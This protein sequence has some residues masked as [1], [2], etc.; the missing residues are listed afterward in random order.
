MKIGFILRNLVFLGLFACVFSTLRASSFIPLTQDELVSSADAIIRGHVQSLDSTRDESGNIVTFIGIAVDHDFL[1]QIPAG[2]TLYF[3]E[4]GGSFQGISAWAYGAAELEVGEDVVV[5]A[6]LQPDGFFQIA[7]MFQGKFGVDN[8]GRLQQDTP[9]EV[10][11]F[12]RQTKQFETLDE[13]ESASRTVTPRGLG[14]FHTELNLERSE[15]LVRFSFRGVSEGGPGGGIKKSTLAGTTTVDQNYTL[16]GGGIRWRQFDTNGTV[17]FFVNTA[18]APGGAAN[19]TTSVNNTIAAWN[20]ISGTHIALV[21]GGSTGLS[22][23][24]L[25]DNTNVISYGDPQG[26]I[27]DP[28]GCAG[29]LAVT[30]VQYTLFPNHVVNGTNFRQLLQADMVFNNGFDC[31]L[32]NLL[33]LSEVTCHEMGHGIGFGHSSENAAEPNFTLRDAQMYYLAHGDGRGASPRADDIAAAQFVYPGSGGGGGGSVTISNISATPFVISPNADGINDT[34]TIQFTL[35]G[36]DVITVEIVDRNGSVIATPLNGSSQ[37]AGIRSVVWNG[38]TA[39]ST[40]ANDGMYTFRIRGNN[41]AAVQGSLGVNNTVPEV[42]RTWFLAEGSTVGFQ[43]YVLVQN[44]NNSPVTVTLTFF[45]Q[46]GTTPTYSEVVPPLTRTTVAVHGQVPN[47]FSVSTRVDATLPVLVERAM[48]FNNNTGGSDTIGSV[49]TSRTWYFPGNHT[50]AGDEDFVLIVNPS[51]STAATITATFFFEGQA[52]GSQV[53]TVN[54]NSRYTI[55]IHGVT[56][57]TRVAVS[58]Q[59]TMPVVAERAFYI[60]NRAGGSSGL[61]AASTSLTWY[62]A[63]GDTSNLTSTSPATTLL[64]LMNPTGTPANVTVNF[65][66]ENGSVTTRNYT[67]GAQRLLTVDAASQVGA[68]LRFGMEVLSNTPIVAE[69]LMFSGTDVGDSIGSPTTAYVWNLAEGFT[70]FGYETWVIVNN[71]GTQTANLT[72]RYLQQNGTNLVQN[73][74][75]PAKQRLTLYVNSFVPPTSVSTQVSSDQPIVVERTMKFAARLGMHQSM[76]VRQ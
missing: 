14:R 60:T 3:K 20:G 18:N 16:T 68:G 49:G 64:S 62:F 32:A 6:K 65:M 74:A 29:T 2:T 44:P 71:P 36:A 15:K 28:V 35:S 5:F 45:K 12:K 52:P 13:I 27:T 48:Y 47:T 33:N 8:A 63:E 40:V 69:R 4:L 21:N 66:L 1:R 39:S 61:G 56:P 10:T 73:Y 7:H 75:L 50:F 55:P 22:G 72:V 17:S 23:Y 51:T 26:I 53:Y 67:V 19:A 41:A 70:A 24:N 76:G 25:S 38:L 34:T 37:G 31:F 43:T 59:S 30:Y 54:P 11:I 9:G 42:S 57:G 46:D 58:L